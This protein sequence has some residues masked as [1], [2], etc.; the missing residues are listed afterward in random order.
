[1]NLILLPIQNLIHHKNIA[2]SS[3]HHRGQFIDRQQHQSNNHQQVCLIYLVLRFQMNELF[4]L[5]DVY[6]Y[7]SLFPWIQAPGS[8]VNVNTDPRQDKKARQTG[9]PDQKH[10]QRISDSAR[11]AGT[12]AG[13]GYAQEFVEVFPYNE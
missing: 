1:M 3:E 12:F 13:P 2:V 4:D 9:I 11:W 6:I 10:K 8:S 5:S 7:F